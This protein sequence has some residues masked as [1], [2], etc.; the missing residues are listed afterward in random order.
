MQHTDKELKQWEIHVQSVYRAG[1]LPR[2]YVEMAEK[3]G[4]VVWRDATA[5]FTK[6][7]CIE[8]LQRV[9]KQLHRVP[10]A[11][12]FTKHASMCATTAIVMF[13]TWNAALAAAGLVLL[14]AVGITKA[15]MVAEIKRLH[16]KLGHPPTTEDFTK[17]TTVGSKGTAYTLFSSW[18]KA[19]RSS[20][21]TPNNPWTFR[22]AR[23][24]KRKA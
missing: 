10:K 20:G 9:A 17:H 3:L 18:K 21:L 12:E 11:E 15:Q 4:K 16:K 7:Q 13:G 6:E 8:E 23:R 2:K 14:R 5:A 1:K 19:L 24:S 22:T